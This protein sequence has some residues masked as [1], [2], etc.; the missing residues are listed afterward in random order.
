MSFKKLYWNLSMSNKTQR[1]EIADEIK[2]LSRKEIEELYIK[3][4]NGEKNSTL[5]DF[6]KIKINPNKLITILPPI[7]LY[8]TLCPYC[9]TPMF[10]KRKSKSSSSLSATP[11]ECFDCNHKIYSNSFRYQ[12]ET[13]ECE[14]CIEI[15]LQIKRLEKEEKQNKILEKYN[16]LKKDPI[17]YIELKFLEKLF[18]LTL[19]RM[20]TN[21]EFKYILSLEILQKLNP[22]HLHIKWI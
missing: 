22:Y 21:E 13:C 18:L 15:R 2:H 10:E 11:I 8:E 1:S 5:V 19:F 9:E 14:S 7:V 17:N 4:M 16:I 6:Y 3:Y 20:Q 12:N